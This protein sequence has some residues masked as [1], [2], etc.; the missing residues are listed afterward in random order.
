[1]QLYGVVSVAY[2]K[3]YIFLKIF[4]SQNIAQY[5]YKSN[6][7]YV[8]IVNSTVYHFHILFFFGIGTHCGLPLRASG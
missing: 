4:S 3:I 5:Y 2:Y 6:A 8:T 1:M 7:L